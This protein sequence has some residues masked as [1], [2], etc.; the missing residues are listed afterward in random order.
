MP[1]CDHV[2]PEQVVE[3]AESALRE[4]GLPPE[5]WEG[6]RYAWSGNVDESTS[7]HVEVVRERGDWRVT[8]LERRKVAVPES[9]TGYRTLA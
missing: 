9:E 5:Q 2:G 1:S 8:K 3:Y 7:V 4:R 6:A